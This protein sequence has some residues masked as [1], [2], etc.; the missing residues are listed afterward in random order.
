MSKPTNKSPA[1]AESAPPIDVEST[2]VASTTSPIVDAPASTALAKATPAGGDRT[3]VYEGQLSEFYEKLESIALANP[4][5]GE[6]LAESMAYLVAR[7]EGMEGN[8]Q[9]PIP[10]IN[11]R[12]GLTKEAKLPSDNVKQ[13][14]LF[15]D[16]ERIGPDVKLILLHAH[17]KR[18]KFAQ[19][20]DRPDCSSNDA[21]TGFKYGSCEQCPHRARDE[22]AGIRAACSFGY[23]FAA[24]S[25]DFKQLYQIDFMKTS[26]GAGKKLLK[27]ASHPQ[28]IFSRSFR[29][30]TS[31][32]KND[33]G[34]YWVLAVAPT[35]DKVTGAEYDAA[36]ILSQF[37]TARYA[38]MQSRPSGEERAGAALNATA[39]ASGAAHAETNAD[40]A[41]DFSGAG[42]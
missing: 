20:S 25:T 3:V 19:G 27:L 33:K 11:M 29:I 23:A 26:S 38:F 42:L 13:G 2:T 37:F 34:E 7:V 32:E 17:N 5:L 14:D 21:V 9:V 36:R 35:G 41:P 16:L 24:V 31:K 40:A 30:Y 8:R 10:Y 6:N 39:S 22:A 1:P 18:V 28:G 12:Q 15:T 4:E